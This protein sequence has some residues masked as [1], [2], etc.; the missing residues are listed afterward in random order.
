MDNIPDA[1]IGMIGDREKSAFV[2]LYVS[3]RVRIACLNHMTGIVIPT[4]PSTITS[5]TCPGDLL[6][7]GRVPEGVVSLHLTSISET[8]HGND[9]PA[10]LVH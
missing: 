5:L 3:R 9:Q 1:V 10:R 7:G 6:L 2:L 8:Y 4:L